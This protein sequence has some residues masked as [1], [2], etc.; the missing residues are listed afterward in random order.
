M[1]KYQQVIDWINQ[2][3]DNGTLKPG[4]R[5]PSE[6]E[7]CEQF[8]LSRQTVRHAI[9]MLS[10]EGLT[11]IVIVFSFLRNAMQTQSIPPNSVLMGLSL[12]LT[13]FVMWPTFTPK[14][15][16]EPLWQLSQPMWTII[17]SPVPSEAWR[18]P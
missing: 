15:A 16:R 8:G 7:L 12:F 10:S 14:K 3:I 2:N 11:R 18:I 1:A 5:I 4:E 17:F 9:A 13:L 6:N